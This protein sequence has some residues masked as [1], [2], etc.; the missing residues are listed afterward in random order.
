MNCNNPTYGTRSPLV[1]SYFK[2]K[3]LFFFIFSKLIFLWT[4]HSDPYK[5]SQFENV[6]I[7]HRVHFRSK[8]KGV[9]CVISHFLL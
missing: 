8:Y 6:T 7:L 2:K 3:I 5:M 9:L 1:D 4:S